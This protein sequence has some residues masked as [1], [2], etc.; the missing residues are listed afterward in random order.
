MNAIVP[1]PPPSPP[2]VPSL[3]PWPTAKQLRQYTKL[4]DQLAAHERRMS[5]AF[6]HLQDH[7]RDAGALKEAKA[8]LE[9]YKN[10]QT[11]KTFLGDEFEKLRDACNPDD[12]WEETDSGF[13]VRQSEVTRMI[14]GKLLTAFPT[15]NIQSPEDFIDQM[16]EDVASWRPGFVELENA[17]R[18][19]RQTKKFMPATSEL[20]EAY[21]A[22]KE[23]WEPRWD[24]MC[25]ETIT[26]KELAKLVE[27]GSIWLK[28]RVMHAEFG[29]GTVD[30]A[31]HT[32]EGR[33]LT[34]SV[35]FDDDQCHGAIKAEALVKLK[36]GDEGFA[37]A[38]EV[39]ARREAAERKKGDLSA[40]P[41]KA[42]P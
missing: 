25:I 8:A 18:T 35:L 11:R 2:I 26:F 4:L 20:K 19:L 23:E 16:A 15:S 12:W 7:P 27:D 6:D 17:C 13:D 28:D 40:S 37:V 32:P 41:P 22:A 1:T 36:P 33:K 38:P 9:S 21:E 30:A 24:A 5:K 31:S 42:F 34:F 3:S 10:S 29:P 14:V 39:I